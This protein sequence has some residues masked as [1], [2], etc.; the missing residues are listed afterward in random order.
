LVLLVAGGLAGGIY[1]WWRQ[2]Y[3]SPATLTGPNLLQ[4]NDFRI[5]ADGDKFPDGWTARDRGGIHLHGHAAQLDGINNYLGSP[6]IAVQPKQSFRVAFRVMTDNADKPSPT[7]VRVR[8]HWRDAEGA[9]FSN[10]PGEWQEAPYGR[11]ATISSTAE[12]PPGAAQL[13]ISIHPASDDRIVVDELNLGQ[14]GVRIAP[15]PQGKQAALAL[16]FDYE[17]AMGGLIHSRGDDPNVKLNP[18]ERARRMRHGAEDILKLFTDAQIR[19]TW[20][21]NGYNFLT[22][23]RERRTF[24]GNP[25]YSQWATAKNGWT[26][27][28]WKTTPWFGPDPYTDEQTDPAWYFGSQ[29]ASL[30]AAGQDI[31]SHTFAHF[32]GG[33]VTPADWR[34]DFKA[35]DDVAAAMDVAKP[36]SLAFPWSW[37][38]GMRG[39]NWDVLEANGITSVTR[40]NWRQQ[41]FRLADRETYA[42]RRIPGH[43]SITVIADEYLTTKS[44]PDV[45]QRLE[46]ARVNEGAIDIWAHTEEVTSPEQQAAWKAIIAARDPFWVA[47]VPDI[48]AWNRAMERVSVQLLTEQPRYTFRVRNDNPDQLKGLTLVLPFAPKH[49]TVDGKDLQPAGDRL[50]IDLAG[51]T[52]VEVVLW[53]A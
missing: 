51:R 47:S 25:I 19:G 20:Y 32:P 10:V 35:W 38:A 53:P 27:D 48:A 3:A 16:S 13:S 50:V 29:I 42:P 36:T 9:E 2:S 23:N 40:T 31:Q 21:T 22:G 17:T 24:M 45:Q 26:T 14:V 7:R 8:F 30:K 46:A 34:A 12:A 4:N 1:K 28:T 6:F 37:T 49:V 44:L 5:D 18:E 39:D 41:R 52:S 11:W 15:W 33:L 43:E